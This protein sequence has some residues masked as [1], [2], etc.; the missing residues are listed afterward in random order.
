MQLRV[1]NQAFLAR[2]FSPLR[3]LFFKIYFCRTPWNFGALNAF[4]FMEVLR[5]FHGTASVSSI[6]GVIP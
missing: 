6:T 4:S 1:A 2:A 5:N 3:A